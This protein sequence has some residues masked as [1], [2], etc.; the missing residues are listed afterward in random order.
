MPV[1]RHSTESAKA[2]IFGDI[3][4]APLTLPCDATSAVEELRM[5]VGQHV[6]NADADL[7]AITQHYGIPSLWH[8]TSRENV[9]TI[10]AQGLLSR[11]RMQQ[12]EMPLVDISEATVQ[13]HRVAKG[14]RNGLTLHDHVPM[15]LRARNPMLFCRRD[16]NATLCM[17]EVDAHACLQQQGVLFT[18]G[19]AASNGTHFYDCLSDCSGIVNLA[20]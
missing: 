1:V 16:F 4:S 17:L 12:A 20:T 14:T 7:A 15:Y 6:V 13:S 5:Q 18:D 9:A 19:N 10:L 11:H 3:V 2:K 8:I